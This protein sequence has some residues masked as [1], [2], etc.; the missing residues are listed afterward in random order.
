[1]KKTLKLNRQTVARLSADSIAEAH[2]GMFNDTKGPPTGSGQGNSLCGCA[3]TQN[4]ADRC[5]ICPF[6]APS[7]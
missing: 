3:Y 6:A 1:M 5:L 7:A 4:G 2:G